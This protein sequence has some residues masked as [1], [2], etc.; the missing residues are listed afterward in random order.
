MMLWCLREIIKLE[1]SDNGKAEDIAIVCLNPFDKDFSECHLHYC[2]FR[3]SL[4]VIPFLFGHSTK[5]IS[6]NFRNF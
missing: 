5:F 2:D 3:R 4:N 1:K 6:Q